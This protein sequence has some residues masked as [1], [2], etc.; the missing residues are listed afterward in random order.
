MF[1]DIS[2]EKSTWLKPVMAVV[3][4]THHVQCLDVLLARYAEMF[5]EML[6]INCLSCWTLHCNTISELMKVQRK[7]IGW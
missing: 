4:V 7:V 6:S 2:Q 3:T 5:I 1:Y